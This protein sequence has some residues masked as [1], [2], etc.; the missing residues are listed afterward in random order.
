MLFVPLAFAV[1]DV[2]TAV[3]GTVKKI[4]HGSKTAVIATKD[5]TEHTVHFV[6]STTVHG[7]DATAT[8]TKDAFHGIKEGSNVMVHYT[9]KGGKKTAHEVD[10]LGEG[11]V[12]VTEG[13]ISHVDRGAKT[14]A[15]KTASG[16]EETYQLSKD[17]AKNV[18][19]GVEKT[20]Q[21]SVYYTEEGGKKIAHF[22]KKA[23]N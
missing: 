20:G 9:E 13:T 15:V 2:A 11:G 16:A 1:Q 23:V 19:K 14:V 18:G 7:A 17:G 12:K 5:G 10:R 3:E 6:G 8:G 21:V 4:D 22:F